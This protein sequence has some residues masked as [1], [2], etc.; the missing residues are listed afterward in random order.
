[1][2]LRMTYLRGVNVNLFTY[3]YD[4]TWMAFF[5]DADLRIYSRY[6]SRD[7]ASADA[8]NSAEGLLHTMKRVL[9]V[10]KEESANEQPAP[11][12]P[13]ALVP[14]E[15]PGLSALGY[16]GSCV[17]CHMVHEAKI[18]QKRKEGKLELADMWLY[19][20]PDNIG[21]QIDPKVGNV[22]RAVTPNSFAAKAG[23]KEGDHVH[24]AN[25]TRILTIADIQFVL[26]SLEPK[27]KLT[28]EVQRGSKLLKAEMELEGDWRRWDVSWRKSI[29][30]LSNRWSQLP[31][32]LKAI[33][34]E[35]RTK[36]GIKDGDLGLRLLNNVA[37]AQKA[38][39]QKD[40]VLVAFDGKRSVIYR[41]A[42]LYMYLEHK[43]GDKM[44]VTYVRD[45]KEAT[46]TLIVP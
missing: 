36:L 4:Q 45:G 26:S 3:D 5:M 17:R 10:H 7:A 42:H 30:L 13:K 46:A 19:P 27:S 25:G 22:V 35:E 38:G 37:E 16:G 18:Y 28:L 43:S 8:H 33:P 9:E 41:Q 23:L 32:S 40:D 39:L 1:M 6:G 12:L 24:R 14:A 31:R 2:L 20:L 15:M 11:M 29:R 34:A 44:E 21:M